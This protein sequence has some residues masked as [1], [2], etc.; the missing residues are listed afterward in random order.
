MMSAQPTKMKKGK[1][2]T[3]ASKADKYDLYQQSVQSPEFEADFMA[4]AFKK[5]YKREATV[6]RED[7]LRHPRR[8]L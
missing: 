1:K 7:F 2:V 8:V 4:K 5:H 3:M 6:L